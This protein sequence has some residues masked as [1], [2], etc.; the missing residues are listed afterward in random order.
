MLIHDVNFDIKDDP[1]HQNS[2]K[3]P[4]ISLKYDLVLDAYL[5]MLGHWKM[6]YNSIMSYADYTWW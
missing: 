2:S 1:N 6:A 4:L 3:E 5:I